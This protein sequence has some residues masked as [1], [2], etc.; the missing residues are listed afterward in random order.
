M[1]KNAASYRVHDISNGSQ[2]CSC[3]AEA[4]GCIHTDANGV[5]LA[6]L[7][8]L[9]DDGNPLQGA[10][11]GDPV[12]SLAD[13]D[14]GLTRKLELR[15]DGRRGQEQRDVTWSLDGIMFAWTSHTDREKGLFMAHAESQ[16]ERLAAL[17]V[18]LDE[19][20]YSGGAWTLD[21]IELDIDISLT[22]SNP[23]RKR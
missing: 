13:I 21:Q 2:L 6:E 4:P 8:R 10:G 18:L 9:A 15:Q 11:P 1:T 19:L 23:N 14:T 12:T 16:R 20:G 22:E 7:G 3:P 17:R 5:P